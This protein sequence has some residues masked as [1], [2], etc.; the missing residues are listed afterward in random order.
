MIQ[1]YAKKVLLFAAMFAVTA[2]VLNRFAPEGVKQY[3]RI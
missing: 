1:T 2:F 3:F